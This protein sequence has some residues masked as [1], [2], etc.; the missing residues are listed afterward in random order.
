MGGASIEIHQ[1]TTVEITLDNNTAY[2]IWD[3]SFLLARH[4]DNKDYFKSGY[5]S[6]KRCIEL[7]AGCGLVSMA[8]WLLGA[9]VVV[10]DLSD[11]LT[12]T[13]KCVDINVHRLCST[14]EN[15]NEQGEFEKRRTHQMSH[16]KCDSFRPDNITVLP[17]TW[18]TDPTKLN[19]PFDVILASDIIYKPDLTDDIIRSLALLSHPSTILLLSYKPR[20]LGEDIFFPKLKTEGYQCKLVPAEDHPS[21]F[22]SSCYDLFH[23]IKT[24]DS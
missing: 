2:K 16:S 19:P 7:G 12:H 6:N 10:T 20:S 13:K 8:A 14:N 11:C 21:E 23:I 3:G 15:Q 5:F 4:L 17:Y 9:S 1:D 22:R 18:G 24:V